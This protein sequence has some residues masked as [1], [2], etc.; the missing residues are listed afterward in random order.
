MAG[1]VNYL[2][3]AQ[4]GGSPYD[5]E[6]YMK[7]APSPNYWLD[8]RLSNRIGNGMMMEYMRGSDKGWGSDGLGYVPRNR[9]D[10]QDERFN[11]GLQPG[12]IAPGSDSDMMQIYGPED[13]V[14]YDQAG[15]PIP[16]ADPRH[17]NNSRSQNF[18]M[19]APMYP[20]RR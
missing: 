14:A 12:M 9:S 6:A 15:R 3:M 5:E 13:Q 4:A 11:G 17:P 1:S 2:Q 8:R 19:P 10:A 16:L 18:L 7:D 20:Q